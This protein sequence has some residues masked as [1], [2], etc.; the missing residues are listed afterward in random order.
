MAELSAE[1]ATAARL[2]VDAVSIRNGYVYWLE[3]RPATGRTALVRVRLAC[4]DR[5]QTMTPDDFDVGSRVHEYGGGAYWVADDD[6]IF[7]VNYP[8]QRVYKITDGAAQ[9]IT[10]SSGS[11]A[12]VRYADLRTLPDDRIICVRERH[13]RDGQ[14]VNELVTLPTGTPG[15]A[16]VVGQGR[17][18][19]SFPRPNPSGSHLAFTCWDN[20]Q[21]PWQGTELWLADIGPDRSITDARRIAGSPN[22]SLFQ[23]EWSPDGH[24]Y[25]MSDRTG[26]WN[27]YR[28]QSGE[29][30]PVYP[31]EA[32]CGEPQWEFGYSTFAF[33]NAR[34]IV[35]LSRDRGE[36]RLL[37]VDVPS[38]RAEELT[39]GTTSIKA[40][41]AAGDGHLAYIGSTPTQLPI[42]LVRSAGSVNERS[43][44]GPQSPVSA[45]SVTRPERHWVHLDGRPPI[46]IWLHQPAVP[47]E[48][49]PPLVVRPHPG[50]T[51]QTR[52]RLDLDVQFFTSRGFAV[53][54]VDYRGST[55]YGR[56]FR[57]AL[58]Q[59]WGIADAEDCITVARWLIDGERADP[60][61][62]VI[63]GLSA[64]GFTALRALLLSDVFA[65]AT[66]VSGIVDLVRY[67]QRTHKFQRYELDYLVGP[68]PDDLLRYETRSPLNLVEQIERPVFIAHG[69]D[70]RVVPAAEIK[71]F[72]ENMR[73]HGKSYIARFFEGEG[74]PPS[75]PNNRADLLNTEIAF[76]EAVFADAGNS[77]RGRQA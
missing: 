73:L 41:L 19:Y 7:V 66:C 13:E 57:R 77:W 8:D 38:G 53:V 48:R 33:L 35:I 49:L 4:D 71:T 50:P 55:G 69:L 37:L 9:A 32:E 47:S 72:V 25:V 17:D 44:L 76:Y 62:T 67:R 45:L 40:Y 16:A 20:P 60:A 34:Q 6:A 46:P 59:L 3:T 18:F 61:R 63:S 23:P 52:P 12:T 15:P 31:V 58:R 30:E 74:H 14:V 51:S 10:P 42:V 5:P 27:L 1:Q 65:A 2:D 70:D 56:E 68:L 75:K 43:P 24:L 26:W 21:M 64:G 36:D 39:T 11:S 28:V 29:L 22:E 54:D